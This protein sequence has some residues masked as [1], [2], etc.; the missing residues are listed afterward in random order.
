M[1]VSRN[2]P[3]AAERA[4]DAGDDLATLRGVVAGDARAFTAFY[5]R[6]ARHVARV[7]YRVMGDDRDLDDVVQ[8]TFVHAARRAGAI[9]DP[10]AV[11]AWLIA[12]AVRRAR[13]L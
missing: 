1:T 2:Q 9:R 3:M 7:L 5:L 6:H 11:S 12:V 8:E 13:R 4:A 10:G